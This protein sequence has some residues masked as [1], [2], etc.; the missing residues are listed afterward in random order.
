M[1]KGKWET[2]NWKW[3]M[4]NGKWEMENGN[5]GYLGFFWMSRISRIS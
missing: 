5:L 2:G 4:G 1:E 3:E